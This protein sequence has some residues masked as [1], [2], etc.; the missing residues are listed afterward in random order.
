MRSYHDLVEEARK[1]INETDASTLHS[2][3]R[4]LVIDVRERE[5]YVQGAIPDAV[6]I[7]R[8]V[9]EGSVERMVPDRTTPMVLYCASGQRSALAA[10]TLQEM[11]YRNVSNLRGGYFGW[12][13]EVDSTPENDVTPD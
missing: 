1:Q 11:G 6:L 5:E 4:P 13:E 8:G 10:L 2:V 9:L 3:P 7:P 12:R